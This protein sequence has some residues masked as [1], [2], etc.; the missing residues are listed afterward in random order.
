MGTRSLTYVFDGEEPIV[1]MYR[2][3]DGYPSGHG[4]DLAEFLKPIEIVNGLRPGSDNKTIANGAG[5][6]A[7]QMIAQF[8]N[9]PGGIYLQSVN[10]KDYSWIDYVYKIHVDSE[11]LSY[12]VEI[13]GVL[14]KCPIEEFIEF[15]EK[16][17]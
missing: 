14:N 11:S 6:L 10:D 16:D 5:C 15:C 1:C 2:Q 13:D 9:E 8:K 17:E 4:K 12:E 3:F 7:A